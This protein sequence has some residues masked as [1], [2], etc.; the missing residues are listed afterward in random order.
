MNIEIYTLEGCGPCHVVKSYLDQKGYDYSEYNV[1]RD[2]SADEFI[3]KF[4]EAE[5]YPHTL[6]NGKFIDDLMLYLEGGL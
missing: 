6:V 3:E 5:G 4:P 1:P 2:L